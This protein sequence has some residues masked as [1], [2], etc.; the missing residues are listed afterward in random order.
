M[1][2]S[3]YCILLAPLLLAGCGGDEDLNKKPVV[4]APSLV[5]TA[6]A[7]AAKLASGTDGMSAQ[8]N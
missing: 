7:V 3:R 2:V 4:S 5:Q 1:R 6:S 8:R